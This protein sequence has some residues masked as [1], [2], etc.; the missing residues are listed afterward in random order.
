MPGFLGDD[1]ARV[2]Q[3]KNRLHFILKSFLSACLCAQ[4]WRLF[5]S[6]FCESPSVAAGFWHYG[7]SL[8]SSIYCYTVWRK[9]ALRSELHKA[10]GIGFEMRFDILQ[11]AHRS[12]VNGSAVLPAIRIVDAN[13]AYSH[14][15]LVQ[16]RTSSDGSSGF[17]TVCGMNL[18]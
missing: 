3:G 15:G 5:A 2:S 10:S 12:L 6:I 7:L 14:V 13:G 18:V 16:V 1:L 17:G 4:C 8:L 11:Q 9:R